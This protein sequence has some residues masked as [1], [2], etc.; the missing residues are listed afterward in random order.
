M[1]PEL[2]IARRYLVARKSLGVIHAIST[3]SAIGMAVGTAALI[4]ILSVYNGFDRV[5]EESLSDLSPD[6]LVTPA[7]GKYFVP[8]GPAFDA[9]LDDPRVAQIC[10]VV[11]E[12]VFV[13]YGGRQQLAR[14]KGVDAVYEAESRLADH[15]VEGAFALHDGS[16]PQAAVGVALAREMGIRP[17]FVDPL[18]LYYPRRGARIPLAGPAAAL[19]SVKLHPAALLSLTASTDEELIILPIDQMQ[20][21]LGLTDQVTGI[22]LRLATNA[23][24]TSSS[25]TSSFTNRDG[26]QTNSA[27]QGSSTANRTGSGSNSSQ[28]GSASQDSNTANRTGANSDQTSSANQNSA[29]SQTGSKS[30]Q[31][32]PANQTGTS[33]NRTDS[34]SGQIVSPSVNQTIPSSSINRGLSSTRTGRKFLRELQELLGPD[35]LVQDR[36]QQQPALYKMMRYEKLAIYLIL[37]FVVIIIASNIF[38]SLSMLSI[39]KRGDMETLRA[40][41]ANDRLVRRIFVWEGWLVSL[42][43]LAAGLVV[44]LALTLAQQH[45]GFVKMPGGFF[46]QAYPVVLQPTD[47]LWTALG[48]AVV[49]FAI[50]LLA[51]PPL[52]S[53]MR[54][55]L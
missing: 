45:F 17:H 38:G 26:F 18:T 43:G 30:D 39:A 14:A 5:I 55:E 10:S 19:G 28:P 52:L 29:A 27:N 12:Q 20:T 49:G 41:G 35:Y 34:D 31:S 33:G 24:V 13:A 48:V 46:L 2:Y 51:S 21:L 40:M 32:S 47:I 54:C 11:E 25:Q 22:E 37:L 44:G 7:S 16:L 6:V 42:I 9:L 23:P 36:V 15:V 3:L 4:L 50:S 8:A 1:R 53:R